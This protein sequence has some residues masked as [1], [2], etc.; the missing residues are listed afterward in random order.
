MR[1]KLLVGSLLVLTLILL[2]PNVPAI[3]ERSIENN[4]LNYKDDFWDYPIINFLGLLTA[5]RI[6]RGLG[7]MQYAGA[8]L[9]DQDY[10]EIKHPL[11]FLRGWWLAYTGD[12]FSDFLYIIAQ[13]IGWEW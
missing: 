6:L 11:L 13:I 9:I 10:T 5:I 8:D 1:M 3:Q 2:M 4:K 12:A 7:V